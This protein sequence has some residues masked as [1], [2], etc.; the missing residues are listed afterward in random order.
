MSRSPAVRRFMR[1]SVG[2]AL[3]AGSL[4]FLAAA[5][6]AASPADGPFIACGYS[7]P[8]P[9]TTDSGCESLD[10]ALSD[11]ATFGAQFASPIT[12]TLMPG[13]Y[14]PVTLPNYSRNMTLIGAGIAGLDTSGG[15]A[16]FSGPEADLTS[17]VWNAACTGSQSY[18]IAT[19][20]HDTHILGS[21]ILDNLAVIGA[22]GGPTGGISI[23]NTGLRT[24]DV[25][26]KGFTGGTGVTYRYTFPQGF[27]DLDVENSAFLNSQTGISTQTEGSIDGSTI[28]GNTTGIDAHDN[29]NLAADTI[30]H[31]TTGI[32]MAS[33]SQVA[34]DV[35]IVGDNTT[36][37]TGQVSSDFE[38]TGGSVGSS[39]ANLL[40]TTCITNHTSGD[41]ADI[42]I[43]P[44][45]VGAVGLNGGPTESIL[46]PSQAQGH[47]VAGSCGGSLT[48]ADQ[49][50]YLE[51][52]S[53]CDIG[54]VDSAGN[55]TPAPAAGNPT[56]AFGSV[57]TD[58][59]AELS[60]TLDNGGGDLIG[61][62]GLSF[63]D[64]TDPHFTIPANGD[65]CQF[66]TLTSEQGR[67]CYVTVQAAPP[68]DGVEIT[69]TLI[70]HT[71]G[72]NVDIALAATGAPAITAA[73]PP[74]AVTGTA[75]NGKVT[76][77][78]VAPTDNGGQPIDQY[79]V[80]YSTHSTGPWTPADTTSEL[81][82]SVTGLH[83]GT[84]YFFEVAANNDFALGDYSDPSAAVTPHAP[85]QPS[86]LTPIAATTIAEGKSLTLTTTLTDTT[87]HAAI[88]GGTLDLVAGGARTSATTDSHGIATTVV[89][90]TA[91]TSYQWT[92]AGSSGHGAASTPTVRVSVA[93]VVQAKLSAKKV[94]HH[95]VVEVY[96]TVSPKAAGQ[97]VTLL[98]Y[99]AGNNKTTRIAAVKIKR[100][101]MP[102]RKV[103]VGFVFSYTP[104]TK[105]TETLAVSRAKTATNASGRSK[106]LT[107]KVS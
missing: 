85:T 35:S 76:V 26:V 25:E 73:G 74:T 15:P 31:N 1:A 5:P 17:F 99:R 71:T 91:N 21:V 37:C 60:T 75:G 97:L 92:F 12:V 83:N 56:F 81:S 38:P 64:D 13:D 20:D 52:I 90:P 67:Y 43:T 79:D 30:S 96:G 69:G 53:T 6:A 105:G 65:G 48:K 103:E 100:Q 44:G 47:G 72:G 82:E 70:V 40:G 62:T 63:S 32:A 80:Q 54:S 61:V 87:T 19:P 104:S 2:G 95:K 24:R 9:I 34:A 58:V 77:H 29:L 66:A 11:A 8:I 101:R 86:A 106:R 18:D 68:T 28:A 50:E 98:R 51:G 46:P 55:G 7:T 27:G 89:K 23:D 3:I 16:T 88:A 49:R 102:N 10:Q 84:A 22:A 41:E 57:P 39:G 33:G 94:K 107:L 45:T 78:W 36:D 4:T 14:C 42:A 93:Q 59:P